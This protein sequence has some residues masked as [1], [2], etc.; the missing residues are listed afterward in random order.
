MELPDDL[1]ADVRPRVL[2]KLAAEPIEDLRL[3]FEDGYHGADEDADA[4]SAAAAWRTRPQRPARPA[5]RW[6]T[7]RAG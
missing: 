4:R 7:A 2:A 5:P 1:A 3:D 6:P